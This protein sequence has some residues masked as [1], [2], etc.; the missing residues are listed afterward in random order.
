M[1]NVSATV[2]WWFMIVVA[3]FWKIQFPFSARKC[4]TNRRI[5]YIHIACVL[6][7]TLLP[8]VPIIIQI[9]KFAKDVNFDNT[10]FLDGGL[11]FTI[12]RLP[13]LSCFSIDSDVLFYT[14]LIP[15]VILLAIGSAFILLLYWLIHK[16]G[17][18]MMES[19]AR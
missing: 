15:A 11:G 1:Y 12:T 7:G 17:C 18:G 8:L 9:V 3:I 4:Q 16:V 10:L 5:K 6:I 19:S 13:P 2:I 14:T